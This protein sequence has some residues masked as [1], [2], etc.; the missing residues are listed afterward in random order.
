MEHQDLVLKTIMMSTGEEIELD[1]FMELQEIA[2]SLMGSIDSFI[3]LILSNLRNSYII[4]SVL[5]DLCNFLFGEFSH[6]SIAINGY[7]ELGGWK[8]PIVVKRT[9]YN[10][11][12]IK[13]PQ[14]DIYNLDD[15]FQSCVCRWEKVK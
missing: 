4:D 2:H 8:Y 3:D 6:Y 7:D 14:G 13:S 10:S 12:M 9:I 5:V 15:Y 1:D 11:V